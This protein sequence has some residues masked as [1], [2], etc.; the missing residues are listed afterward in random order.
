MLLSMP[1]W[2]LYGK[3]RPVSIGIK[4][5]LRL[6]SGFLAFFAEAVGTGLG[7]LYNKNSR[8]DNS[9]F[10]SPTSVIG[11]DV[12]VLYNNMFLN[13]KEKSPLR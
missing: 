9:R 8:R 10:Q 1:L 11:R 12:Y 7:T 2:I 5:Q 13:C 3:I 4:L 6:F